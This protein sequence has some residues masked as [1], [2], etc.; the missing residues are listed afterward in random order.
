[1]AMQYIMLGAGHKF[2]DLGFPFS[3][4]NLLA[5]DDCPHFTFTKAGVG[6]NAT[7]K[8]TVDYFFTTPDIINLL[9][10]L[11]YLSLSSFD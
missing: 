9:E 4:A 5:K 7:Y 1:M 10:L 2:L 8:S 3:I 6:P 11:Y